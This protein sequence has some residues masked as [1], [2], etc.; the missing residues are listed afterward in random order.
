VSELLEE[1]KDWLDGLRTSVKVLIAQCRR[2]VR[3][4]WRLRNNVEWD[5][6]ALLEL[7]VLK[8]R[9]LL[10]NFE[11]Y[12]SHDPA[13]PSYGPKMKSLRLA[14]KLGDLLLRDSYLK[15]VEAHYA[16]WGRP[17]IVFKPEESK[18]T[19]KLE[20]ERDGK[21]HKPSAQ[22]TTELREAWE[23]DHRREQKHRRW[24]YAIIR[25]HGQ[26]WWD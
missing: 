16:K 13:C 24:F 10:H 21:P 3:W 14:I 23:A 7:E 25:E 1:A 20:W 11:T 17:K 12:G 5:Y 9:E 4:G 18:I 19:S 22:E 15:F 8:L 2:F 6:Y 26:R